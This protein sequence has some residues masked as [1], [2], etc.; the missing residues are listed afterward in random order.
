MLMAPNHVLVRI[1][2][3]LTL[4]FPDTVAGRNARHL[5]TT[6]VLL[7]CRWKQRAPGA[8]EHGEHRHA[9][10]FL[11]AG[12]RL[13]LEMECARLADNAGVFDLQRNVWLCAPITSL[14]V[15]TRRKA[16]ARNR[17]GM[18]AALQTGTHT[19]Y[20]RRRGLCVGIEVATQRPKTCPP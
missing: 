19:G 20:M 14:H 5:S 4:F 16:P 2:A 13:R 8:H 6:R 9:V 18:N 1:T 12:I 7:L 11:C 17:H 10:Q 15:N 3:S